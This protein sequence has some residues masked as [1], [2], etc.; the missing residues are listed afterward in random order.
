LVYEQAKNNFEIVKEDVKKYKSN[1]NDVSVESLQER[2]R[3]L[4]KQFSKLVVCLVFASEPTDKEIFSR[5]KGIGIN[6]RKRIRYELKISIVI[7]SMLIFAAVTFVSTYALAILSKDINGIDS[8]QSLLISLA[9]VLIICFPIMLVFVLKALCPVT[10]PVRGQYSEYQLT[11]TVTMFFFGVMV[12]LIGFYLISYTGLLKTMNWYHFWPYTMMSGVISSLSAIVIDFRP[13]VWNLTHAGLRAVNCGVVALLLFFV[14]AIFSVIVVNDVKPEWQ[15]IHTALTQHKFVLFMAII[16]GFMSGV[17]ISL[18]G[19]YSVKIR[20]KDVELLLNVSEY[21]L[22]KLGFK[23]VIYKDCDEI[24]KQFS[25]IKN[26][27]PNGLYDYLVSMKFINEE[28]SLTNNSIDK[29][30]ANLHQVST[31]S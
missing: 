25:E 9:A 10:W 13:R 21:L 2:T 18:L 17:I 28:G 6:L 5:L 16:V 29:L 8:D 19:E 14:I 11:P 30:K 3:F 31:A 27:L 24:N 26:D 15:A 7:I 20:N 12:G 4:L 1:I 22:P 23:F